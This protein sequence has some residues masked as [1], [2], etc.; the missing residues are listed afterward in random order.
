MLIHLLEA[1]YRMRNRILFIVALIAGQSAL[2]TNAHAQFGAPS[3][4]L[5]RIGF[6]GGV[7][8][9]IGDVDKAFDSGINGQA[10]VLVN[11]MGLPLRFNL[12]YQKLELK[13]SFPS[14]GGNTQILSGVGALK[15]NLLP[16]P[17]RPYVTAG[18]GAFSVKT[19]VENI[20][21][22][23]QFK[24]GIDG[25]AGIGFNL[26]RLEGFIEGRIQNIYTDQGAIDFKSIRVIPVSVGILF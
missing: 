5:I 7:S 1:G 21:S 26:G 3:Q 18:V 24:F 14:G 11:L 20:D 25:G 4:H 2:A 8:V 10:Y 16:G 19:E 12:G 13:E 15:I 6:G 17:V 23:S 22:E 9:P